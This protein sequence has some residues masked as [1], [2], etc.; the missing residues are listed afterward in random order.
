MPQMWAKNDVFCTLCGTAVSKSKC[1]LGGRKGGTEN[2]KGR[3]DGIGRGGRA[4]VV[5]GWGG[6]IAGC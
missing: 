2:V 1:L 6:E 4:D 3:M 5:I